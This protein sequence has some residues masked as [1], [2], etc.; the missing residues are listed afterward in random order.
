M[1][2]KTIYKTV[3]SYTI[4]TDKP[5]SDR[6]L[7]DIDLQNIGG[8][9]IGGDFKTVVLNQELVGKNAV[10]AVTSLD[11][12]IDFFMMD[13]NGNDLSEDIDEDSEIEDNIN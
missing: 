13:A 11:S 4:L 3:I 5:Y 6:Y 8:D 12:D 2:K 9:W 10:N 7:N 1:P